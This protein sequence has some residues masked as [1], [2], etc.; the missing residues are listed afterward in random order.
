[1]SLTF[2]KTR[3]SERYDK[4]KKIWNDNPNHRGKDAI[5]P[6]P[7][8]KSCLDGAKNGLARVVAQ[9]RTGHWK[10]AVYLKRIKK[11]T[12]DRCWHCNMGRTMIRSH[13]LLHYSNASI[14]VAKQDVWEG[15]LL[16]SIR[17]LLSNP[18]WEKRLLHFLELSGVGRV[19]DNGKDEEETP[20]V[21][22]DG[23]IIWDTRED[24]ASV[25][26]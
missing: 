14:V 13:V 7:P 19:L 3:I 18:C 23:W 24:M 20:A 17:V 26:D 8:K 21:K 15:V 11:R 10:S 6:P 12:D 1:M 4:A 2:L 25:L 16:G 9:I 5:D 22:M